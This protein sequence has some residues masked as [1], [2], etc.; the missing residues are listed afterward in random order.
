MLKVVPTMEILLTMIL[1]KIKFNNLINGIN[2][3]KIFNVIINDYDIINVYTDV[4]I[5]H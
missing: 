3:K 4:I 5:M 2:F 1:T